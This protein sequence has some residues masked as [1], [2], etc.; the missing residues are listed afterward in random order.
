MSKIT[1]AW[2]QP[3]RDSLS[4][5]LDHVETIVAIE[6]LTAAQGV[7]LRRKR[8]GDGAAAQG[9]GTRVAYGLIRE[10]VPFL[11]R[12]RPLSPLIEAVRKLV[13]DGVIKETV[14]SQVT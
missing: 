10:K 14:E 3:L 4:Q 12:D 5:I 1:S 9:D 13:A 7:D 8:M 11:D 6:L 2:A